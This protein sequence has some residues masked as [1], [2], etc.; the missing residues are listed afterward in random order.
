MSAK[1]LKKGIEKGEVSTADLL[2]VIRRLEAKL[3]RLEAENRRLRKRLEQYEPVP[4]PTAEDEAAPTD[5]SLASEE[6]RRTRRRAK[7]KRRGRRRTEV[8]LEAATVWDDVYPPGA[9]PKDC[10][11]ARQRVAWRIIEGRAVL[12]GYR[13]Y[14]RRGSLKVPRVP[15]LLPRAEYGVEVMV[16]LAFLTCTMRVS[17]DQ[18]CALLKF[19]CDLPIA[20]SQANALLNQLATHWQ[21]EFETLCEL[22]A[23][24]M[25]VYMDETSW[26]VG[27]E[28]S[29]LWVFLTALHSLYTFGCPKDEATLDRILPPDVFRGTGVSD[30][31]AVYHERFDSGQKCWAHL[32]RKLI[33]LTLLYPEK[34]LYRTFLDEV[35]AIFQQAKRYQ[36][37]GRLSP[38][39]RERKVAELSATLLALCQRFEK[40]WLHPRTPDEQKFTNLVLELLKID[41]HEELFTFV[42]FPEVEAT[43]NAAERALRGAAADRKLGRTSKSAAGAHRRSVLVSVLESL[44]KNLANFTLTNVVAEVR[45]WLQ[46]GVSLFRQQLD[47]LKAKLLAESAPTPAAAGTSCPRRE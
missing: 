20:K 41:G 46:T 16:V 7:P 15:G 31:A 38:A 32:L 30:D 17:L 23:L 25:V 6:K 26:P 43:N 9:A 14:R 5:Y 29:S 36:R 18:A 35:Y 8:K 21:P 13:V 44:R 40:Q 11:L 33:A 42:R 24:A 37:D 27:A 1:D 34:P 3:A 2:E 4:A 10:V 28:K 12:V 45:R 47:D 19:F 22:I 39:G